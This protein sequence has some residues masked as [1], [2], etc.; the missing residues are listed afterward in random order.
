MF[1]GLDQ[2]WVDEQVRLAHAG[3]LPCVPRRRET[4]EPPP[5]RCRPAEG[6]TLTKVLRA[7]R[8]ICSGDVSPE[9]AEARLAEC[10]R[11]L[12]ECCTETAEGLWCGCCGCGQ[13]S[14]GGISSSLQYKVSKRGHECPRG[15][16]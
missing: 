7:A 11:R 3:E 15:V 1:Q 14:A 10:R 4:P 6:L 2:A 9:V 16:Y 12:G 5:R 13:W 8:T